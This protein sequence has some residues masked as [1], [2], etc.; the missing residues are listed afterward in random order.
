MI[1]S[2]SV[3]DK[4]ARLKPDKYLNRRRAP[5]V[6]VVVVLQ[7]FSSRHL[8]MIGLF[9]LYKESDDF[10]LFIGKILALAF[11]PV[12]DVEEYFKILRSEAPMGCLEFTEYF[13]TNYVLGKLEFGMLMC[14]N[15]LKLRK[16]SFVP[17]LF[18]ENLW[19]RA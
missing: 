19:H 6:R 9:E 11:L 7:F 18:M 12:D 14:Q 15:N 10:K 16:V 17:T 2:L 13:A 1:T 3:N 8:Q 4:T 5:R